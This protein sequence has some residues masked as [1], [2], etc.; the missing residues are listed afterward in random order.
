MEMRKEKRTL[1]M[2]RSHLCNKSKSVWLPA[3]L[4]LALAM[5]QKLLQRRKNLKGDGYRKISRK[6]KVPLFLKEKK[7]CKVVAVVRFG[8]GGV[9]GANCLHCR[10]CHLGDIQDEGRERRKDKMATCLSTLSYKR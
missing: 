10:C 3:L 2:S 4:S 8:G 9:G 6:G 1:K 7:V 5:L